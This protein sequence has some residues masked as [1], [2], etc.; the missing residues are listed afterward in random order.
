M[1]MLCTSE[2]DGFTI[3][4]TYELLGCIGE[5]VALTDDD[6]EECVIYEGYFDI[7]QSTD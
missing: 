1:K 5:Y 4:K 6:G 2:V 7:L 3:G